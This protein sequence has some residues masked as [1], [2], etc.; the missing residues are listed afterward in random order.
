MT[1]LTRRQIGLFS[2]RGVRLHFMLPNLSAPQGQS[3]ASS[4]IGGRRRRRQPQGAYNRQNSD[5]RDRLTLIDQSET[6]TTCFTPSLYR[7][8]PAASRSITHS[9]D[10]LQSGYGHHPKVTGP[11]NGASIA[12][13]KDG[14]RWADG[15][16]GSLW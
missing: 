16:N 1:R 6:Y 9:Y 5:R 8:L 7:W 11:G 12:G 13:A 10:A 2:Q 3:P 14:E 15:S 4:V